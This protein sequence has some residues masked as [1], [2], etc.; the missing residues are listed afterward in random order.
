MT[1]RVDGGN[2]E[3]GAQRSWSTGDELH[4]PSIARNQQ[5]FSVDVTE[6]ASQ[7]GVSTLEIC[8]CGG[9]GGKDHVTRYQ[10]R[11]AVLQAAGPEGRLLGKIQR[12]LVG[13]RPPLG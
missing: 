5:R 1:A 6:V 3:R 13:G 8:A 4:R 10:D 9:H 11:P 12:E 2:P 7:H